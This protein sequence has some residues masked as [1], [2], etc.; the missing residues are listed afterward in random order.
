ML[1]PERDSGLSAIGHKSIAGST[2][3]KEN[4]TMLNKNNYIA[5]QVCENGK[6]YAYVLKVRQSDNLKQILNKRTL[7]SANICATKIEAETITRYWNEC[8]KSNGTYMFDT[9]QF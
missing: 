7:Y 1:S 3:K 2:T 9:P 4:K 6:Y 8:F 5:I